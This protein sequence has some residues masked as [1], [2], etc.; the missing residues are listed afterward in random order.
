[1]RELRFRALKHLQH[2]H[3]GV[4]VQLIEA[5]LHF[6][7]IHQHAMRQH[8]VEPLDQLMHVEALLSLFRSEDIHIVQ[9]QRIPLHLPLNR[10]PQSYD[11]SKIVAIR[12]LLVREIP[13][14]H[15]AAQIIASLVLL[16]LPKPHLARL[17]VDN[18]IERVQL[19]HLRVRHGLEMNSARR[20][21]K[22]LISRAF[23]RCEL[24]ELVQADLSLLPIE[25][26]HSGHLLHVVVLEVVDLRADHRPQIRVHSLRGRRRVALFR[27][28]RCGPAL[29]EQAAERE[30]VGR[31]GLQLGHGDRDFVVVDDVFVGEEH[32]QFDVIHIGH[33]VRALFDHAHNESLDRL[34]QRPRLLVDSEGHFGRVW[35]GD[36]HSQN[37]GRQRELLVLYA[38]KLPLKSY[39]LRR[40]ACSRRGPC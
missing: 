28:G 23:S 11:Q 13:S 31:A 24:R 3:R 39:S 22:T 4:L 27:G 7:R 36:V 1:M 37:R 21:R 26:L 12:V 9:L 14:I 8:Q 15:H 25:S 32:L 16:L 17:R 38:V 20:L 34:F 40:A 18:H 29:R 5:L 35:R 10:S 30:L 19:L 2:A 6:L 33:V